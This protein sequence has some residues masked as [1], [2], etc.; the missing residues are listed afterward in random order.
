M[1]AAICSVPGAMSSS[2]HPISFTLS[3]ARDVDQIPFIFYY[4]FHKFDTLIPFAGIFSKINNNLLINFSFRKF[5][6]IQEFLYYQ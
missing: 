1:D 4:K 2:I 5:S 6:S 3:G